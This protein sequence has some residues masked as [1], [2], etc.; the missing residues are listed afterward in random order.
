[1]KKVGRTK[2]IT[3]DSK[4]DKLF[5]NLGNLTKT[6]D[7]LAIG[8]AKGFENT[9]TKDDIKQIWQTM[10]SGFSRQG[11]DIH[12]IKM[13]LGPLARIAGIQDKKIHEIE[14]RLSRL[15]RHVIH[16]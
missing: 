13:S 4:V 16:K 11:D 5:S 9:A 15:E 3:L 14:T 10:T 7:K 2:K 1:M 6:V 8:V 12:D